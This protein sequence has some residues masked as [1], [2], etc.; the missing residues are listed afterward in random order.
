MNLMR[1]CY[2]VPQMIDDI[3]RRKAVFEAVATNDKGDPARQPQGGFAPVLAEDGKPLRAS[4]LLGSWSDGTGL[5]H[6][7]LHR[8]GKV[9]E[10]SN[11]VLSKPGDVKETKLDDGKISRVARTVPGYHPY[12][13]ADAELRIKDGKPVLGTDGRPVFNIVDPTWVLY[14]S[15][16]GTFAIAGAPAQ[17][18][19]AAPAPTTEV[20]DEAAA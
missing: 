8:G 9:T 6:A 13:R 7:E 12:V 1:L 3:S 4:L 11:F 5:L 2:I 20:A 18:A 15:A 10:V 17:T 19:A 16:T 14:A